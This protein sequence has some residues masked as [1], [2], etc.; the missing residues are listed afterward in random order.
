MLDRVGSAGHRFVPLSRRDVID[1]CTTDERLDD[2]EQLRRLCD[3]LVATIHAEHHDRL[4]ALKEAYAPFDPNVDT[5][6]VRH[7][8]PEELADS[9]H[10]FAEELRSVLEAANFEEVTEDDIGVALAGESLLEVRLHVDFDDFEEVAF[11]WRGAHRRRETITKLLGLVKRDIEFVNYERVVMY[12]Q[13]RERE[14]F[15]E[16]RRDDLPFEPGSTMLKMFRDVPRPDL[17][18]LFPNT[19]VRMRPVDKVMIGVPAVVGGVVVIATKLVAS[20]G[21][22]L[23][24]LG[25]WLG[26]TDA[27]VELD[28]TQL[29]AL[30]AGL[31][32]VGGYLLRQLAKFKSRKIRFMKTLADSLYFK[33]L[34]NDAGVFHHLVDAAEEEDAKEAILAYWWLLVNGPMDAPALDRGVEG[35]LASRCGH[36]VDFEISDALGKLHDFGLVENRRGGVRAVSIDEAWHR[37]DER[38]DDRFQRQCVEERP[39]F[40][41]LRAVVAR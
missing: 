41:R 21:V 38:W 28:E 37:L 2:G 29:V 10:R 31:G 32:S 17:D 16:K 1:L 4:E 9:K 27:D 34:D 23:V 7:L 5:R 39:L 12:V 13:L 6:P 40:R 22:L 30:G 33:N 18:M 19:E 24:L 25:A 8:S 26:L 14:H 35:W 20:L 36:P 15:D 3:L 11:F